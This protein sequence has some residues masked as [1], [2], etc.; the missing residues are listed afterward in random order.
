MPLSNKRRDV[1]AIPLNACHNETYDM[2]TAKQS[3]ANARRP[4]CA[5]T[6]YGQDYQPIVL[7]PATQRYQARGGLELRWTRGRGALTRAKSA[8]L[9][10]PSAQHPF[11]TPLRDN[12]GAA[13]IL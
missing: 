7:D 10:A 5:F 1:A 6:P 9:V 12:T 13:R 11:N 4:R 3:H 2:H 8:E